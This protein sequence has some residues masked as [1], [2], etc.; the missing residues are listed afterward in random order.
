[1]AVLADWEEGVEPFL[2]T[3]KNMM[4]FPVYFC[5]KGEPVHCASMKIYIKIGE[6]ERRAF[7]CPDEP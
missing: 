5:S 2:T 4:V 3:A 7:R 1:M 6:R